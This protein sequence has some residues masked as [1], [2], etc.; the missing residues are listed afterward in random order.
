MDEI[1][2]QK[3]EEMLSK[4]GFVF[5]SFELLCDMD[6]E[7]IERYESLKKLHNGERERDTG[8]TS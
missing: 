5:P 6:P 7:L 1:G 2:K 3:Y 4:R 8:E